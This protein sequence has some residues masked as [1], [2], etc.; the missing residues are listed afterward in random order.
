MNFSPQ[1]LRDETAVIGCKIQPS[2]KQY[3]H[4]RALGGA[5]G[6]LRKEGNTLISASFN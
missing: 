5:C 3:G 4:V 1:R 2:S 6:I